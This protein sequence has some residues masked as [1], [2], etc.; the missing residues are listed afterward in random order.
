M[1]VT[2]IMRQAKVADSLEISPRP[3]SMLAFVA[4]CSIFL[5]SNLLQSVIILNFTRNSS[6]GLS[7]RVRGSRRSTVR[8]GEF[9]R[10]RLVWTRSAPIR[11][12]YVKLRQCI[13][14]LRHSSGMR[15]LVCGARK[16]FRQILSGENGELRHLF[17]AIISA[18]G[19]AAVVHSAGGLVWSAGLI[20]F[21]IR[22]K[23][24]VQ[25]C[26]NDA[27]SLRPAGVGADAERLGT[28]GVAGAVWS[29]ALIGRPKRRPR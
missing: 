21:C 3:D 4:M 15:R 23:G 20:S 9:V 8:M 26:R 18:L 14:K 11:R 19:R 2:Q 5:P 16:F 29:S 28:A 22:T 13:A 17:C 7:Q 6:N 10:V 27:A 12:S 25:E 24:A 1:P